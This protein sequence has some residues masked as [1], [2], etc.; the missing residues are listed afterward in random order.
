MSMVYSGEIGVPVNAYA[1][2]YATPEM[3][4][5]F[6]E[7]AK[8]VYERELWITVMEAQAGLGVD[9]PETAIEDYRRVRDDVDLDS[10]RAREEVTH[11]DVKARIEEFDELAGHQYAHQGMT[12][13][14]ATDNMEQ[15]Q[16]RSGLEIIR[17]RTVAVLGRFARRA[18]E[19]SDLPMAGR[20]HNVAGQVI[21]LGTRF[22][23]AGGELLHGFYRIEDMI[24]NYP[25]RG[26]KGA[27]G[28]QQDMLDL[29]GGDEEK[30]KALEVSIAKKLGFDEIMVNTGQVYPR[31]FDF[32]VISALKTA[33][34][35]ASSF[36]NT[37]RLMAGFELATEGFEPGRVGSSAM[38]HKRNASKSERIVGMNRTL[39]GYVAQAA[40]QSGEQWQEGDV[41]CSVMRREM[42]PNAFYITDGM[43]TAT[44]RILDGFGAYPAVIQN[45]LD[46]YLPFLT[47]T[48]VLMASVKAGMGREDAHEVIK[49]HAVAVAV[50][51]AETGR[52]ENDL[53]ERLANDPRLPLDREEIDA[54]VGD[55]PLELTGSARNSVQKFVKDVEGLIEEYPEAAN[56]TPPKGV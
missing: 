40:S 46:K 33:A 17:N 37:L 55:D 10:I 16:I 41:S 38:P 21:T 29:L 11:H 30:M 14:D 36:A 20:S 54:A 43:L 25:L 1:E 9:I 12:S 42:I 4:A 45:E 15:F 47:S 28:T 35:G 34:G 23:N 39:N 22:A 27:M 50:E 44:M 2:R 31:S 19:Y 13:R 5:I 49:E 32:D 6:D 18:A 24:D 7:K 56:Y 8:V 53:F 26:I 51:M 48:K 52:E 3:L